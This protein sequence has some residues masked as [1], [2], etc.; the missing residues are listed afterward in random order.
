MRHSRH[1]SLGIADFK[2][3]LH[4]EM[5]NKLERDE[6]RLRL[7]ALSNQQTRQSREKRIRDLKNSLQS[8]KMAEV[9]FFKETFNLQKE[10]S[11]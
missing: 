5:L 2:I 4:Q 9:R 6:D 3:K 7:L 10:K 11:R 8:S 1:R